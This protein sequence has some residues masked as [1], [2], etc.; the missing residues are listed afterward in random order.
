MNPNY[1]AENQALMAPLQP[2]LRWIVPDD[3]A[4]LTR[5]VETR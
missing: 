2:D 5:S 4:H 3:I 1:M